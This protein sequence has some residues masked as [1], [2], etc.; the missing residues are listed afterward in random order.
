[1]EFLKEL[2]Q[3]RSKQDGKIGMIA[4]EILSISSRL[5]SP[6][7]RKDEMCRQLRLVLH[8]HGFDEFVVVSHS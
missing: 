1:M 2:N 3:G 4:V 7:L 5:T 8:R 6:M